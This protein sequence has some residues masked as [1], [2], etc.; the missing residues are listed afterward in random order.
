M[1]TLKENFLKSR[2]KAKNSTLRTYIT[3]ARTIARSIGHEINSPADIAKYKDEIFATFKDLTPTVANNRQS[4][5]SVLLGDDPKYASIKKELQKHMLQNAED[6]QAM[7]GIKSE[8]EEENWIPWP[9]VVKKYKELE[10]QTK[11]S[12]QKDAKLSN[13]DFKKVQLYVLMSCLVLIPVRRAMDFTEFKLKGESDDYNYCKGNTFVFNV[14]KTAKTHGKQ[15]I[16]IP[17]K[18]RNII[19]KWRTINTS[20]WLLVGQDRTKKIVPS[21]MNRI[22]NDFLG[23]GVSVSI[24]RK[25]FFT[26]FKKTQKPTP[27]EVKKVAFEQAHSVEQANAEYLKV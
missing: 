10:E 1:S 20:D 7:Y 12:F 9:D 2:P 13:A 26:W 5:L 16:K 25:I 8:K 19:A 18:L 24:L 6:K 14:Y 27:A 22:L 17:V 21:Q 15:V 4:T 3:N 11:S 23:D